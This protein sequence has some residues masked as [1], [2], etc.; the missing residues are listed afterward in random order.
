MTVVRSPIDDKENYE[1]DSVISVTGDD[2][3]DEDNL[4]NQEILVSRPTSSACRRFTSHKCVTKIM[5]G[6]SRSVQMRGRIM[7]NCEQKGLERST[8][9]ESGSMRYS[10]WVSGYAV[11]E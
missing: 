10:G 2:N 9:A 11:F 7:D 8:M 4:S 5:P 6:N 3:S 1:L